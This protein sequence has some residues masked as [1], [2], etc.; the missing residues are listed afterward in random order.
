MGRL[1]ARSRRRNVLT[2]RRFGCVG[3]GWTFAVP[4]REVGAFAEQHHA[5][6]PVEPEIVDVVVVGE[7]GA[8]DWRR[9]H[10]AVGPHTVVVGTALAQID[11][12]PTDVVTSGLFVAAFSP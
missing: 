12:T 6:E 10:V 2:T 7:V 5:S 3:A 1:R 4:D 8:F 9:A 11:F